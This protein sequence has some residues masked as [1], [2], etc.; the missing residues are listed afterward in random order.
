MYI[1]YGYVDVY[2]PYSNSLKDKRRI[3]Q[4]VIDRIRKRLNISIREI[5]YHN[6]WQRSTIGFAAVSDSNAEL[7]KITNIIKDTLYEHDSDLEITA[8]EYDI[9]SQ[10]F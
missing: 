10:K 4:S 3:I 2:M 7:E 1:V 5:N 8:I 9:I 6:L